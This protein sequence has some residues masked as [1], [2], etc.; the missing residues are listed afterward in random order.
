[1]NHKLITA[2]QLTDFQKTSLLSVLRVIV[3]VADC[4]FRFVIKIGSV[5]DI[6]LKQ[7]PKVHILQ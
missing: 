2:Q 6:K 5:L 3:I 7:E 1:M 4:C